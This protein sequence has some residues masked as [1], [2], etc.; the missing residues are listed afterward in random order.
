MLPEVIRSL[1]L[2]AVAPLHDSENA[3]VV[4]VAATASV[5][6]ATVAPLLSSR[7]NVA[8]PSGDE[9]ATWK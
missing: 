1:P 8:V 6:D 5:C 4:G 7:M 9:Y 3:V 2:P